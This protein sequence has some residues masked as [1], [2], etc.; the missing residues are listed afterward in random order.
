MTETQHPSVHRSAVLWE[1]WGGLVQSV[2]SQG[3]VPEALG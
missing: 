1:K 2:M 3:W